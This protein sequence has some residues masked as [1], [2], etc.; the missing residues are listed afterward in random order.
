[1]HN[2][3]VRAQCVHY[4]EK[5]VLEWL[6]LL[7]LEMEN[8]FVVMHLVSSF[9]TNLEQVIFELFR[10]VLLDLMKYVARIARRLQPVTL[11]AHIRL[12]GLLGAT[13]RHQAI[14]LVFV[15]VDLN[16][17]IGMR[18][19]QG[20]R[21]TRHPVRVRI[22]MR[23]WGRH[24]ICGRDRSMIRVRGRRDWRRDDGRRRRVSWRRNGRRWRIG[25]HR[26]RRRRGLKNRDL[27]LRQR[28]EKRLRYTRVEGLCNPNL[29]GGRQAVLKVSLD[30]EHV[31]LVLFLELSLLF[32]RFE[33]S[34]SFFF[35]L[36]FVGAVLFSSHALLEG[37]ISLFVCFG[38]GG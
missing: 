31:G 37:V 19:G 21:I 18:K 6:S 30:L 12:D 7:L 14:A 33:S 16:R 28:G 25:R 29:K 38:H 22:V 4:Q 32:L 36:I 23:D 10:D 24:E 2:F 17:S 26:Q 1:M 3:P 20:N 13:H 5:A 15:H 9:Q 11:G 8:P 35:F 27:C 34:P